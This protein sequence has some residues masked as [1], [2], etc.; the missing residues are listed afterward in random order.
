VKERVGERRPA[1]L[2]PDPGWRTS[3]EVGDIAERG[4]F[5]PFGLAVGRVDPE[6]DA[7]GRRSG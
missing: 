3:Y 2:A 1:Y 4:L 5:R 6:V 7:T